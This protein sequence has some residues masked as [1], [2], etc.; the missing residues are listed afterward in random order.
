M[1]FGTTKRLTL[2]KERQLEIKV[3]ETSINCTTQYKYLGVT[4]DPQGCSK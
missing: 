2:L 4:L 1:L 3:G